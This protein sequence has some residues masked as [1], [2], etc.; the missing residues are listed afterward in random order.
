MSC[1]GGRRRSGGGGQLGGGGR[2]GNVGKAWALARCLLGS[3]RTFWMSSASF[4]LVDMSI[5]AAPPSSA[6]LAGWKCRSTLRDERNMKEWSR[7]GALLPQEPVS[8]LARRL[9][10]LHHV[11]ASL[12]SLQQSMPLSYKERLL[13]RW[14]QTDKGSKQQRNGWA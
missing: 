6:S 11:R 10:C 14:K 3:V 1:A 9:C 8:R 7:Q 12:L 4:I 5:L 13:S 2:G